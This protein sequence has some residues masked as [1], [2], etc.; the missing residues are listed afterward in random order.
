MEDRLRNVE[1]KVTRMEVLLEE[2]VVQNRLL[3]TLLLGKDGQPGVVVRLDRLEQDRHRMSRM[4][5]VVLGAATTAL[6]KAFL[7]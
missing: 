7:A 3:N 1:D 2:L 6:A 5:W 4:F